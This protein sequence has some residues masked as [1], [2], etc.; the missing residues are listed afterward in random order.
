MGLDAWIGL[1]DKKAEGDWTWTADNSKV[2]FTNWF[3][4]EP[5]GHRRENCAMF[6]RH[7]LGWNDAMCMFPASFICE[8]N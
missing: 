3:P 7:G 4:G 1:S 5:N 6:F 2:S 8:K